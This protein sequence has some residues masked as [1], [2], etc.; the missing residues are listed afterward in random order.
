[1]IA[2]AGGP[3]ARTAIDE[4]LMERPMLANHS[5]HDSLEHAEAVGFY[6]IVGMIAVAAL[7]LGGIFMIST[8]AL[9]GIATL[10]AGL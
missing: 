7:A 6:S 9:S 3:A 4:Y 2:H 8:K 5:G 10:L 1:M